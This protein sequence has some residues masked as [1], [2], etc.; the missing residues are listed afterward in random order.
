MVRISLGTMNSA[1][2][3]ADCAFG[4]GPHVFLTVLIYSKMHRAKTAAPY[5][6]LD[7][8]LIDSMHGSTIVV[9]AAIVGVRIKGFL[10]AS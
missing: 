7:Y 8:V 1:Y 6:L 2:T 3:V 4:G 9:S 5:L 10:H